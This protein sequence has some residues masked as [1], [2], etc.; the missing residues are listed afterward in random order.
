VLGWDTLVAGE[1]VTLRA[2]LERAGKTLAP[3]DL[4]IASHARCHDAILVT[5]DTVFPQ[6]PKLVC[7]D[8]TP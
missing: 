5:N 1:Y 2:Q 7:E 3:R 4:L 6:V 8:W